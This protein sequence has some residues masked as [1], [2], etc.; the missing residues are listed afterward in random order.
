M[1]STFQIV[2]LSGVIL[3]LG[4]RIR[5]YLEVRAFK[6]AHNCQPPIRAPQS[7]RILGLS[8]YKKL[9]QIRKDRITL[10]ETLRRAKDVGHTNTAVVLGQYIVSTCDPECIKTVLATNFTDYGIGPRIHAMGP[11]LGKGIFTLDDVPWQ[12]SRVS[13]ALEP[14]DLEVG[15]SDTH[16][17]NRL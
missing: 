2:A 14:M 4:L 10:Q 15:S 8:A 5:R 7:E 1:L 3:L 6:K 11:L 9:Q 12:H 17:L 13:A 16:S